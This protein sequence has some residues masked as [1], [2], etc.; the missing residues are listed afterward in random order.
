M[1]SLGQLVGG[2]MAAYFLDTYGRRPTMVVGALFMELSTALL[3]W[4]PNVGTVIAA[5]VIEGISI[6][7]LLLGYQVSR[8]RLQVVHLTLTDLRGRDC[9][10]RRSGLRLQ[11]YADDGQLLWSAGCG[12]HLRN[13]VLIFQRRMES[14]AQRHFHPG[15]DPAVCDALGARVPYVQCCCPS[16]P[17]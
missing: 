7:Y 9:C 6:G 8:P 15:N 12:H 14:R 4:S 10:E 17:S 16:V 1:Y 3:V 5:R 13:L 2:L 11:L